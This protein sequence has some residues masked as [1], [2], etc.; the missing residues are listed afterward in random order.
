M[1]RSADAAETRP[2]GS[3]LPARSESRAE[4]ARRSVYRSRF[5]LFYLLLAIAAGAAVGALVVLLDRGSPAPAP[6]W[7]EWEP[8]G[9][10]ERRASQIAER[11][12]DPYRLGSGQPLVGITYA[13]PPTI[14][15]PD[16]SPLQL[17]ALA[18]QNTTST[19]A[20]DITAIPA[21]T[22]VMYVQCG[23]GNA[24]SLPGEPTPERGQLLRRQALE[25]ALYSFRYIEGID[26][27]LVLLPPRPHGQAATAV[28]MQRGDL[29]AALEKPLRETLTAPLAPG[30][31]EIT[32]EEARTIDRLTQ[33]RVYQYRPLQQQDGGFVLVLVPALT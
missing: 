6:A 22:S 32:A 13:G 7:T 11:I 15:G 3:T 18:V 21:L 16:G 19:G 4:R 5:G 14:A 17:R 10:A 24:C 1:R 2:V 33:Q 8:V 26:S 30:V 9:S 27:V 25:L 31:G 23:L 28:F 12:S 29:R 20:D